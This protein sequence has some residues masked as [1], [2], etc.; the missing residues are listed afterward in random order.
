MKLS[1]ES[2]GKGGTTAARAFCVDP[3]VNSMQ[4]RGCIFQSVQEV[5]TL[6]V[7]LLVPGVG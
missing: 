6:S 1:H 7:P 5:V 3:M 2:H 4:L